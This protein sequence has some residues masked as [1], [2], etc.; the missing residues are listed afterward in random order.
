M[1]KTL[2]IIR[3]GQ[4][5][6]NKQGIIQ[7]SG[8]DADLNDRGRAQGAAF[9][10]TYKNIPFDKVYISNL[11]RTYQT[12]QK[13]I[14]AGIPYEKLGG[15]NELAWGIYE[16]Q[17]STSENKAAFLKIMRDWMEGRLDEKLQGGESPNELQAKQKQALEVIMSHQEEETVLICMHGRAMRLF[18]CL[19]TGV[20]LTHMDEFPH[21][22]V[23]LYKVTFDGSK[24]EI[25]EFNNSNHLK[26][27]APDL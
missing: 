9:Y 14:E 15:L 2:Y 3:H 22:N 5:D 13:F 17:T 12:V 26:N 6:L 1:I 10:E 27:M 20:D 4:T 16:G 21:Q 24:F 11:K 19:L 25:A 18:L 7:G 8:I 23:I